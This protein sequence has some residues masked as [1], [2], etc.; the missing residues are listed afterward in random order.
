MEYHVQL[1]HRR[2]AATSL[3]SIHHALQVWVRYLLVA[4]RFVLSRQSQSLAY[5]PI[6]AASP[7]L[8]LIS[9]SSSSSSMLL[10]T[11]EE[12]LAL[13]TEYFGAAGAFWLVLFHSTTVLITDMMGT[14][15]L[16]AAVCA[17]LSSLRSLIVFWSRNSFQVLSRCV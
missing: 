4:S 15:S 9:S 1:I 8:L 10:P 2:P 13:A 11:P 14:P 7:P 17:S 12:E 5:H 3:L 6:A 16:A